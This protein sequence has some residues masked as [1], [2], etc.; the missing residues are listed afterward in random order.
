MRKDLIIQMQDRMKTI[1]P[2]SFDMG[3]W[4]SKYDCGTTACIVG[5]CC[6][7]L[8]LKTQEDGVLDLDSYGTASLMLKSISEKLGV[9]FNV[10]QDVF[11]IS[12]LKYLNL[13]KEEQIKL[14]ISSLKELIKD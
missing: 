1:N 2:E 8:E 13:T 14:A 4:G 6:D 11:M 7:I 3:T 10:C 12:R 9:G 5:H